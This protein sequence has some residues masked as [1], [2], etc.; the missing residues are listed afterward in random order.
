MAETLQITD[1]TVPGY[2]RVVR[3]IDPA[4]GL[5]A[6]ISVHDTTMGPALGGLR[7][8]PYASEKEALFDVERLSRGMTYKSA[9][10]KTG[11][12]GG[13]AVILGDPLKVKS[14]KLYL[15]MGRFIDALG[16][17]YIT[18]EDVNTS[19][20]DLEIIRR[21][22]KWVTGLSREDGGS[23]NPSPYTA[24][25]VFLGLKAALAWQLGSDDLKGRTVAIQGVGA[26][27][28]SLAKRLVEAGAKVFA[29]DRHAERLAKLAKEIGFTPVGEEQ[30]LT[31][32]CDVLA[33][34][35]LGAVFNDHTI[36]ALKCKVIAGAANNLLLAPKHGKDLQ[37]RGILYAPD[38]VINAGGIINVGMEFAEGG[39]NEKNALHH[40]ERIPEALKEVWTIARDERIP[41]SDAA[42]KLAERILADA[43]GKKKGASCGVPPAGQPRRTGGG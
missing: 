30:I 6:I 16:G 10:A 25:G 35:A 38:Y 9:V 37:D 24:Y 22:T 8:W 11:L 2:E 31:M 32:D 15:A 14:E 20:G 18:A 39:Y 40:I 33:P 7:M 12:G 41:P 27:G 42:D 4:S 29:A 3:A 21:A 43:R 19:I 28:S 13:K 36:P 23:G 1:I 17:K 34:C 5:H 26:V